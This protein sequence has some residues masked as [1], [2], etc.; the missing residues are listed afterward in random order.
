MEV[1]P[2]FSCS[3]GPTL[4]MCVCVCVCVHTHV[5]RGNDK[6]AFHIFCLYLNL[7]TL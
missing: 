3:L 6:A 2:L 7:A 4:C 1:R 5:R